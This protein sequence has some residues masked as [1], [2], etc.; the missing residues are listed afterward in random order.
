MPGDKFHLGN[1]VVTKILEKSSTDI[2][3]LN[4]FVERDL[5]GETTYSSSNAKSSLKP[6]IAHYLAL[7]LNNLYR[8]IDT[9]KEQNQKLMKQI[10]S[11]RY[12]LNK[13]RDKRDF[14]R[15]K[16]SLSDKKNVSF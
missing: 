16:I 6:E 13:V 3:W 5:F 9:L 7:K 15:L 4:K 8:T 12:L 1:D 11:S 10:L 14:Y 2:Q